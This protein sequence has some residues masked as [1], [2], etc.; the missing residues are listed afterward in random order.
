[1]N[2][3]HYSR[4]GVLRGIRLRST[5]IELEPLEALVE[6]GR[7]YAKD[8]VAVARVHR[9]KGDRVAL[10]LHGAAKGQRRERTHSNEFRIARS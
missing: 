2:S 5:R 9:S 6:L 3:R 10:T 1:M 4:G 7:W 8:A